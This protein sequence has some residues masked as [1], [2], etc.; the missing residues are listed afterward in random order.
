MEELIVAKAKELFFSF[1]IK[2]VSMDDISRNGAIS[3]KTIYKCF[4]DKNQLVQHLVGELLLCCKAGLNQSNAQARNA[5]EEV[6]LASQATLHAVSTITPAFF[7]DLKKFFPGKNC[8]SALASIASRPTILLLLGVLTFGHLHA[9]QATT[10]TLKDALK[11]ALD[12]SQNARK[13]KLDVE[14]S[15]YK[16]DEVKARALP[17]LSGSGGLTY[18]PILQQ[19]A[20]PGDFFGQPGKTVLVAFGQ[21][22]NANASAS[23]SQTIF[24][25]SVFTGLKAA[26]TTAE[27]YR[28][29]AQLTDEQ[30]I[31]QVATSYYQVLVQR[32]KVGVVDSTI[33]NT[34]HTQNILQSLYENGLAKKID[35]DRIAVNISNLRSNRQ[36]LLN[37]VTLLENQLKFYIGMPIVKVIN[38]PEVEFATIQPQAVQQ[39]DT[40]DISGRTEVAVLQ[41]Q[42]ALLRYQKQ[43]TK[44]EYL[45][46]LSL[47]SAYSFQGLSNSFP[48][49]K[50]QQSGVNWFPV[51][52][53]GLNLK[54]PIFN[55]FATRARLRQADVE[56]R[57]L[58]EDMAQTKLSLSLAYENARTQINNSIITLNSQQENVQLARQVY[59]NT[60]NNYNNGL[61]TLTDLLDAENSLTQAQNNYS[62]ALLD[63]KVSEIQLIKAQGTLSTLLN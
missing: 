1:G 38:L 61:A 31:E 16:I 45:P 55:G 25:N 59:A 48:I 56:I 3:K 7:Y 17:Q 36:Q 9:Q 44:S 26:K 49:F 43:A 35:V 51:A 62:A 2:S 24:D 34:V 22:W 21:K 18:N 32:Q 63:F 15:Q 50:G 12:A 47:S 42:E 27:F 11:Y 14:N 40:L 29:N 5:I 13:A 41:T 58:Q 60:Q 8:L 46:S 6:S 19:S 30:I 10:L 4:E 23:L 37:G 20:L 53:V 54:V 57:K 33:R 39:G 28:L 52:S